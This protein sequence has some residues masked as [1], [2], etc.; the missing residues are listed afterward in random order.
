LGEFG[1]RFASYW[2]EGE[3][4][5]FLLERAANSQPLRYHRQVAEAAA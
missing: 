5:G 3:L 1:Y 4:F 2:R